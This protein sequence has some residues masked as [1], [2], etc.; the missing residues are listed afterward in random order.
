MQALGTQDRGLDRGHKG[1]SRG[2]PKDL[3]PRSRPELGTKCP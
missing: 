2:N 3:Y 1:S